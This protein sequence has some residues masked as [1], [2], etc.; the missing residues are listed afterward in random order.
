LPLPPTAIND[1]LY[2]DFPYADLSTSEYKAKQRKNWK[3]G[4]I[5]NDGKIIIPIDKKSKMSQ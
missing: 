3:Y 4:S 1:E 5:V 2:P